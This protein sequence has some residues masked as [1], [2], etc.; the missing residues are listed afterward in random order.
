MKTPARFGLAALMCVL[1]LSQ[2]FAQTPEMTAQAMPKAPGGIAID[3]DITDWGDTLAMYN[4]E[5]RLKYTIAADDNNL[6][7]IALVK[8]RGTKQKVMAGGITIAINTE[9]KKNKT[10]NITYPAPI[11]PDADVTE[12]IAQAHTFQLDGFKGMDSKI[13]LP[14][15]GFNG[16]YAF[17][18]D[19][20][21]SYETAIPLKALNIKPG[22]NDVYISVRLN[23][24]DDNSMVAVTQATKHG[25]KKGGGGGKGGDAKTDGPA[26]GEQGGGPKGDMRPAEFW[27]HF[28]L[29]K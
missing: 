5:T 23:G 2:A 25:G 22:S 15:D 4:K 14:T 11:A 3:G 20:G 16:S 18:D 1:W 29:T 28:T 6:Y 27:M 10:Y 13:K 7:V 19:G 17:N 9:G 26:D 24:I 12:R 8:D 21:M